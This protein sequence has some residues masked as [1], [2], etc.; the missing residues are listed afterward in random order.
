MNLVPRKLKAK[1]GVIMERIGRKSYF[2]MR[3]IC[4]F[5]TKNMEVLKTSRKS[6]CPFWM[7]FTHHLQIYK[8]LDSDL[9]ILIR[10]FWF[11]NQEKNGRA[12][13]KKTY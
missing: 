1:N 4:P 7:E 11:Q 8:H 9:D 3:N 5:L 6:F 12:S 13:S 2:Y 10:C